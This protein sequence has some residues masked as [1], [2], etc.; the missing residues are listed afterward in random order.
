MAVVDHLQVAAALPGYSIGDE[1]GAGGFGLVLAG[2]HRELDRPVAIK[3]LSAGAELAATDDVQAEARLLGRL[4]HPHI[5]RVYDFV[6]R[7]D[8]RLLIMELLPGGTLADLE[9][10]PQAACAVGLAVAAGL[11]AAHDTGVLH[12]DIKPANILFTAG[13]QPKITDFGIAKIFDGSAEATNRMVGTPSY[14]APEQLRR[15][16]LGPATDLFALGVVLYEQLAGRLPVDESLPMQ[17]RLRQQLEVVPPAPPGVPEPVAEVVLRALAKDPADRYPTA[18]DFARALAAA[19]TRAY[20]PD[21]PAR[22]GIHLGVD[23]RF[24]DPD[25]EQA[26]ET[27][28]L[29]TPGI[30][31]FRRATRPPADLASSTSSASSTRSVPS[32]SPASSTRS[33]PPASPASSAGAAEV[34]V[35]PAAHGGPDPGW[36]DLRSGRRGRGRVALAATLVTVLIAAGAVSWLL[37]RGSEPERPASR[38]GRLVWPTTTA[39]LPGSVTSPPPNPG[40]PVPPLIGDLVV[41]PDRTIYLVPQSGSRVLR[42][43]RSGQLETV[44]GQATEGF[45]GDNG[46]AVDAQLRRPSALAFDSVGNLYVLDDGNEN[47]RK[48]DTGGIIST[49]AGHGADENSSLPDVDIYSSDGAL[50][51]DEAGNLYFAALGKIVRLDRSGAVTTVAGKDDDDDGSGTFGEGVPATQAALGQISDILVRDGSLYLAD[52][53]AN[54][55]LRVTPDG[56]IRTVAGTGVD[57]YSG[58]NMPAVASQ[59]SLGGD[60]GLAMDE[61]GNLYIGDDG[62]LRVRRVDTAG[63]ITTVAGDGVSGPYLE[64]RQ[65]TEAHLYGAGVVALD[66]EGNLYI[67]DGDDIRKVDARGMLTLLTGS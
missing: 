27:T 32:T 58:D 23:T 30:D 51:A 5:V 56:I 37:L 29:P 40:K 20:G 35:P 53:E 49:V 8:L 4:D 9:L 67:V 19:A 24:A 43:D 64:G 59:L 48:V 62:N 34:G 44:A 12:R 33:V 47:I 41:V 6:S 26:D 14:M 55:V 17:E 39:G 22:S 45:S 25:P 66:G 65:A 50:A 46:P 2:H 57:G 18:R 7:G 42:I 21:W 10:P 60:S 31:R 3:V 16:P 52:S 63:T 61:A 15:E 54:R 13:G 11:A 36:A 1:L 28:N 38:T